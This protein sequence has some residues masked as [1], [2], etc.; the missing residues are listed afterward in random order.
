MK[1]LCHCVE[2]L[3]LRGGMCFRLRSVSTGFGI[4]HSHQT[5]STSLPLCVHHRL[6]AAVALLSSL[7]KV[8]KARAKGDMHN[9][10]AFAHQ[11]GSAQT[12]M[13]TVQKR[14]F[15]YRLVTLIQIVFLAA[16]SAC[17]FENFLHSQ[18]NT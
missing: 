4:F 14:L 13:I 15:G 16:L 3:I 1:E 9:G 12:L 8:L 10:F 6:A 17:C 7:V 2:E 18:G 5:G 11:Q